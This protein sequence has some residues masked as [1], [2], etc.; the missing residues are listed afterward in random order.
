MVRAWRGALFGALLLGVEARILRITRVGSGELWPA[1][2]RE[3]GAHR[4]KREV[5]SPPLAE[6]AV[7]KETSSASS[8]V[9]SSRLPFSPSEDFSQE[10]EGRDLLQLLALGAQSSS[11]DQDQHR[12]SGVLLGS[13]ELMPEYRPDL[14]DLFRS[15]GKAW[16]SK[17]QRPSSP[18][19]KDL[20]SK[21][22]ERGETRTSS[23]STATPVL[24][25]LSGEEVASVDAETP[26]EKPAASDSVPSEGEAEQKNLNEVQKG[27]GSGGAHYVG[28]GAHGEAVT[29][30]LRGGLAGMVAMG[31]SVVALMP[32][33]TVMNYQLLTGAGFL[34]ALKYLLAAPSPEGGGAPRGLSR[35]YDGVSLALGMAVLCRFGDTFT[36]EWAVRALPSEPIPVWGTEPSTC[37]Q[38]PSWALVSL[39]TATAYALWRLVLMPLDTLKIYVQTAQHSSGGPEAL[40]KKVQANGFFVL[41]DGA[42]ATVGGAWWA[43]LLFWG[44]FNALESVSVL[45]AL[46]GET[47]RHGVIGFLAALFTD[48]GS[49]GFRVLKV[50]VQTSDTRCSYAEALRQA[51][52]KDAEKI[53]TA[54]SGKAEEGEG[55]FLVLEDGL[56]AKLLGSLCWLFRG[57][58]PLLLLRCF[59]S[60]VF[61][62][63]W[64]SLERQFAGVAW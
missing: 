17:N 26:E 47:G 64:K 20:G 62:T 48:L 6:V 25:D 16:R 13:D 5:A 54:A 51:Q 59:Q 60:L 33:R 63:L 31:V 9:S 49:N 8:S 40:R 27:D 46:C 50:S 3:G 14:L 52:A 18:S 21:S 38:M 24:L 45:V 44:A 34:E 30:G 57:L 56:M 37:W 32:L 11:E 55:S 2:H 22:R 23:A 1:A 61:T 7:D 53:K 29:A 42:L 39:C 35:L 4:G 41:F 15:H 12:D 43:S 19:F 28:G 58:T 36:N 10:P